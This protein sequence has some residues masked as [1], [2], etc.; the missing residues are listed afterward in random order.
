MEALHNQIKHY[1]QLAGLSQTQ[2][3]ER[4]G[5]TRQAVSLIEAGQSIP[6]ALVAIRMAH[7]FGLWVE[8]LFAEQ[9]SYGAPDVWHVALDADI[10]PGDRVLPALVGQ[11]KVAHRIDIL[12]Q[13]QMLQ[14]A[15][16]AL[17][18]VENL[19][20]SQVRVRQPAGQLVPDWT[21]VAGCDL[22][23]ALLA[24]HSDSHELSHGSRPLWLSSDNA[25]A[26]R[27]LQAGDVHIAAIHTALSEQSEITPLPACPLEVRKVRFACLELGWLVKWGNP[28][29]FHTAA[30][31]ANK[32]LRLVN[33]PAGA[34]ARKLL[35]SLL[36]QAQVDPTTVNQY[37]FTVAG[38]LQV[39]QAIAAGMA[40]VG[41]GI[42]SAAAAARLAFIPIQTEICDLWIPP[43]HFA[44]EGVQ[45]IL[46]TLASDVF[47]QDLRS[48]G[49]YDVHN[50]GQLV[51]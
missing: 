6:S 36:A 12:H 10:R 8:D 15:A 33:R 41:I 22:G 23:L 4:V 49:P 37:S 2:L 13:P 38:H 50:T 16:E 27:Q 42:A 19:P 18:V 1:R 47:R 24:G 30:D 51:N 3:A 29:G 5:I 21:L 26:L 34:G 9:P 14:Q 43:A 39:A 45:Q 40:D 48:F 44:L 11:R 25:K 17:T 20:E 46:N 7:S 32:H 31:F 35:D 28:L